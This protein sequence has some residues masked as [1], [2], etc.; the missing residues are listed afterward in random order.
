[1]S[2][3]K[4]VRILGLSGLTQWLTMA[5]VA[6][7]FAV[8]CVSSGSDYGGGSS[9][10]GGGNG[11]PAGDCNSNGYCCPSNTPYGCN[12]YCYATYNDGAAAGCTDY[13]T[14]C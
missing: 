8:A 12:G 13:K 1:M 9:S 3:K 10:S 2:Q 14:V 6:C 11:C 5:L 7:L 4:S